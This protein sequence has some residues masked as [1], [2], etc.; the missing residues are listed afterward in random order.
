MFLEKSWKYIKG[1]INLKVEGYFIERFLNLCV[2]QN[3]EIWNIEKINDVELNVNVR[4]QDYKKIEEISK[5]TKCK[6]T[7]NRLRGI[8]NV[9][10][11]YKKRKVFVGIF[12]LACIF[13]YL[14]SVRIWQI[15]IVGNFEIPIEELWEELKIEGVKLGVKKSDLNYS[16]IKNNIY[17]RRNDISWMGFTI[18]GTKAYVEFV[19]R[20][21]KENDTQNEPCNIVAEKE[22]II[23]KI[24]V[25]TGEKLVNV[26]DFVTKGEILISGKTKSGETYDKYVSADGEIIIKTWYTNKV[27]VPY[28]KDIVSK[29]GKNE[30]KYKLEIGNYKINFANSST[31]F[32]KYD[33]ITV[34]NKLRLFDK[35]ELPI[36]L[37]ELTYE[38]L[39]IDTIKYTKT[40][41][42]NIAKIEA[43]NG[44][45]D[46]IASDY[47]IANESNFLIKENSDSISAEITIEVIEQIGIK[48]KISL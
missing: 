21:N 25:K 48:E 10:L 38:E 41:A 40:Q 23:Q 44:I 11:K 39:K 16:K 27:T 20:T 46:K 5:I 42:E 2:N 45:K 12:W 43:I 9:T 13:I 31:K 33:T 15:E 18:K 22:G 26:G 47:D 32:E 28:E 30:K 8:P 4:Q 34:S 1:Y 17:V 6:L 7:R 37:T 36:K 35:I 29:T 19:E 14:Y 3:I 24:T